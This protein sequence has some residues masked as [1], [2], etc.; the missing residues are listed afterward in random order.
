MWL[1]EQKT[2]D[3]LKQLQSVNVANTP[4]AIRNDLQMSVKDSEALIAIKGI[5]TNTPNYLFQFFGFENTTYPNIVRAL[6]EAE[7]NADVEKIVL[8][9]DSPGGEFAGLFSVVETMQGIAKPVLAIGE[10]MIASAA[11]LIASQANEINAANQASQFGSVG[12]AVDMLVDDNI[13]SI[14]NTD[15][16]KKRPDLKSEEGRAVVQ[17]E[18]DEIHE[19]VV[20]KIAAGRGMAPEIVNK[21]YGQGRTFL[22]NE[23][24]KRGMINGIYEQY[25]P[26]QSEKRVMENKELVLNSQDS[27]EQGRQQGILDERDRVI[28]HL[29]MG[30]SSGDLQTACQAI[31][32]GSTMTESLQARYLSAGLNKRNIEE[33]QS[34]DEE[35]NKTLTDIQHENVSQ[36]EAEIVMHTIEQ[37]LGIGG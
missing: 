6:R 34:D 32:D 14:A 7:E 18:L 5:L 15:S 33:R 16:P 24:L 9:I 19:L 12:V 37:Q 35:L 30:E 13:V 28:A 20:K 3:R 8:S 1:L 2:L 17:E 25:L 21:E 36:S 26:I 4:V 29:I 31:R 10:N 27:F 11:Y 22:A 23:A